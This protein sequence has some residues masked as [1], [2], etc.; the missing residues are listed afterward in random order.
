MMSQRS[1]RN[2]AAFQLITKRYVY[3]IKCA[4]SFDHGV[5]L[6]RIDVRKDNKAKN[7]SKMEVKFVFNWNDEKQLRYDNPIDLF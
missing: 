6:L 3:W 5:E 7:I 4:R 2:G 1:K